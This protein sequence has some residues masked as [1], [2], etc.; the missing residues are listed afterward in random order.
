MAA[1]SHF[2]D[3]APLLPSLSLQ[4]DPTLP[5]LVKASPQVESEVVESRPEAAESSALV[6]GAIRIRVID[7][8]ALFS[9]A[10]A[11]EISEPEISQ[12]AEPAPAPLAAS[13]EPAP[14]EAS[15]LLEV[16]QPLPVSSEPEAPAVEPVMEPQAQPA[17][18]R[19][20]MWVHPVEPVSAPEKFEAAPE[21]KADPRGVVVKLPS[22]GRTEPELVIPGG[23]RDRDALDRLLSAPEPFLGL[24][25][26]VGVVDYTRLLGENGKG[27]IE[28]VAQA[29]EKML[30]SLTR[31][32]D[33]VCRAEADEWV[34]LCPREVAASAQRRITLL[35]ERL[36]DFQ[37]RSLGGISI[38]FSWG[39]SECLGGSLPQALSEAHGEMAHSRRTRRGSLNLSPRS[40]RRVVNG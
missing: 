23:L 3:S 25:L 27:N 40:Q 12:V 36:W 1:V 15:L 18:P 20:A 14:A 10:E 4:A 13:E 32:Y 11:Y 16:Q 17:I 7:E 38:L 37:L 6:S 28:Q 31:D 2:S 8:S 26:S 29:F 30:L 21:A 24:V 9:P 22:P 33:M 19:F 5:V 34:V 35:S 39:A